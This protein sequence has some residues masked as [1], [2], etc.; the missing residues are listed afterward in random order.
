LRNV[1]G[2]ELGPNCCVL[3][4]AGRDGSRTTVASAR[5][6]TPAEWSDDHDTLVD[7]LRSARRKNRL[8][9][10]AHVVAWGLPDSRSSSDFSHLPEL[11]PLVAAGFRIDSMISPIQALADLVRTRDRNDGEARRLS[12]GQGVAALSINHHGVAIAIVADQKVIASRVFDWPLGRPFSASRSEIFERYL[13]ISQLAPEL[14]HLIDLVKPVH[15]VQVTSVLACGNLPN[16][17]SLSMLLI[18]EMDIEV[19]TLDSIDLLDPHGGARFVDIVPALQLAASAASHPAGASAAFGSDGR[20]SGHT[21]QDPEQPVRPP[22]RPP[23]ARR[24]P[25]AW[26]TAVAALILCATWS[27]LELSGS[28]PVRP[29]LD[30]GVDSLLASLPAIPDLPAEATMGRIEPQSLSAARGSQFANSG[31]SA[32]TGHSPAP[33]PGQEAA[34]IQERPANREQRPF[35]VAQGRP[36]HGEGRTAIPRVDGIMIAGDR[37]LAIVDGNVVAVGDFVGPYAVVSIDRDG[38]VLKQ[39]SGQEVRVSVRKRQGGT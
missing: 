8:S 13:L 9:T 2:I 20:S 32:A 21:H 37:R 22:P 31:E 6:V 15:G 29:V 7:L 12:S 30:G 38:V 18:E 39:P 24:S 19:E 5:A 25:S 34:R 36:E 26:L 16:L 27:V 10:H 28:S 33:H 1:T 35:D 23:E 11:G 14:K 3:V 4:R 17:R